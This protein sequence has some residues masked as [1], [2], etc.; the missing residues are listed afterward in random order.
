MIQEWIVKLL[1]ELRGNK[2]MKKK[3]MNGFINWLS[4]VDRPESL[5]IEFLSL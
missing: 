5:F 4:L 3:F 2:S 1:M